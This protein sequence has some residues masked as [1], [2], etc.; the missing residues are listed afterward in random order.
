MQR[1]LLI[2]VIERKFYP[3]SGDPHF[4][5][6]SALQ[7]C[8]VSRVSGG[9]WMMMIAQKVTCDHWSSD[10]L[11]W[12]L[13]YFLKKCIGKE[14]FLNPIWCGGGRKM[15]P[16]SYFCDSPKKINGKSCQFFL[17]FPK[18]VN[19]RLGTTFCSQI[20]FRVVGR[21]LKWSKLPQFH[22]GGPCRE[23]QEGKI[24][25][26][27]RCQVI[28]VAHNFLVIFLLKHPGLGE[29]WG[30]EPFFSQKVQQV[31]GIC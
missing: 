1:S 30:W 10:K 5:A 26:Q 2:I 13:D 12:K 16:L 31:M 21:G 22:K 4:S 25:N 3:V 11:F 17:T 7:F 18:Y 14:R 23:Q 19:G 24:T 27:N 20:T 29:I 8:K 15:P 28:H 9:R 6:M